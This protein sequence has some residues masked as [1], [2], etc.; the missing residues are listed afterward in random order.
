LPHVN[1]RSVTHRALELVDTHKDKEE[2][3]YPRTK[4]RNV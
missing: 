1:I 3:I 4:P 2:A